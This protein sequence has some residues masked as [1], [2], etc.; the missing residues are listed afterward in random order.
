MMR[1]CSSAS[2]AGTEIWWSMK[3]AT[4]ALRAP[5]T[6]VSP[7]ASTSSASGS[8]SSRNGTL[9][10]RASPADSM[11]VEPPTVK[12]SAPNVA[13]FMK[14]RLSMVGMAFLPYGGAQVHAALNGSLAAADGARHRAALEVACLDALEPTF[15]D[16]RVTAIDDTRGWIPPEAMAGPTRRSTLSRAGAGAAGARSEDVKAHRPPARPPL[17]RPQPIASKDWWDGGN[18]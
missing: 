2:S 6:S 14:A 18:R 10:A 9:R 5:R 12:A 13:P 17:T 11:T 16:Q 3:C 7:S 4:P 15:P 1:A 8:L